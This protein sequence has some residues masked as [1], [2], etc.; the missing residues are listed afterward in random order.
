MSVGWA[1]TLAGCQFAQNHENGKKSGR[2]DKWA[3]MVKLVN[4]GKIGK[5]E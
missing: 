1:L 4:N 5:T 2:A 3:K